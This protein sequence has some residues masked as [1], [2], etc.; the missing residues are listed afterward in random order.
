MTSKSS[1]NFAYWCKNSG[2]N[3]GFKGI[4]NSISVSVKSMISLQFTDL[5]LEYY[6]VLFGDD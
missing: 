3:L 4:S 5:S 1:S 6:L 2:W